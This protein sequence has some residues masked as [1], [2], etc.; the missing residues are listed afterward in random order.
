MTAN[1][2]GLFANFAAASL[3][4][5]SFGEG[6]STR[7]AAGKVKNNAKAMINARIQNYSWE[8]AGILKGAREMMSS[9]FST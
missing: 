7:A 8:I 1:I 5:M 3:L 4:S 2:A 9:W 6:M